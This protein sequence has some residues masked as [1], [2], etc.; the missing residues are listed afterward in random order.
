MLP[1]PNYSLLLLDNS[2]KLYARYM[3]IKLQ[4]QFSQVN[5][6]YVEQKTSSKAYSF[7][8]QCYSFHFFSSKICQRNQIAATFID[9]V[10]VFVLVHNIWLLEEYEF[11]LDRTPGIELALFWFCSGQSQQK[12]PFSMPFGVTRDCVQVSLL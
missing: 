11:N 12:Q 3:I 5:V 4:V 2:S 8:D 9:N 7:T 10:L 1:I 6:F